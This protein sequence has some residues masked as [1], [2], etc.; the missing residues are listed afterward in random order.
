MFHLSLDP[1]FDSYLLVAVVAMVLVG[2]M[3]FGPSREKAGRRQR[4]ALALLR[5]IVIGLV[6]LAMLRPTLIYTQTK[7]QAATLVVLADQ[8]RSMSVPD[9]VGNKTR[10]QALRDALNDA[11]PALAKLQRDFEL[12]AYT[13]DADLHEVG[14]EGGKIQLPEKP[15]GQQTAIGAALEDVLDREA[16]KRLLGVVLLSDGA[17][18][19]YA[20]RDL[21]PQTAAARL[22]APRLSAVHGSASASRAG[23]A[24]PRTW[25]SRTCRQSQRVREERTDHH[26]PGPRRR[27][28]QRR[29]SRSACSS[30]RRRARWK[31]SPSRRSAPRPT[32]NSCRSS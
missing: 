8:S 10:W 6:I 15:E 2:L 18:R 26:R 30:R 23:W 5:A 14:A 21:P 12:K 4:V 28:R 24:R 13:F 20:P 31:S 27:L 11:A 7:K 9:A 22:K 32:A 3:W 25:P 1:V 29:Y 16:G 19:A 17:Q